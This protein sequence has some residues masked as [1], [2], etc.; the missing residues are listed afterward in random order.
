VFV[1]ERRWTRES[2]ARS[3]LG[4]VLHPVSHARFINGRVNRTHAAQFCARSGNEVHDDLVY[5]LLWTRII[6]SAAQKLFSSLKT[7][8]RRG[9]RKLNLWSSI[10][11]KSCA[12][13]LSSA[14]RWA[15][16]RGALCR[17]IY[18]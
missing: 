11:A 15:N 8:A 1:G 10:F 4:A 9:Q 12:T 13:D 7:R 17:T 6:L 16:S 18:H 3:I 5:F 2:P 14:I